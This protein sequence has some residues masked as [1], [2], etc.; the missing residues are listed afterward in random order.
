MEGES[1]RHEIR[2]STGRRDTRDFNTTRLRRRGGREKDETRR[3]E[4]AAVS[5][6]ER[7]VVS[8]VSIITSGLSFRSERFKPRM[9]LR[10]RLYPTA[11]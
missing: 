5:D 4:S 11:G 1:G 6:R 3:D 10:I 2:P 7:S 9:K 8:A